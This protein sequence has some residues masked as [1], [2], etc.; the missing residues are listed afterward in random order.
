MSR[1]NLVVVESPAKAKTIGRLLG[2]GY[3]VTASMG[4]IRD[5]PERTLG[6][7]IKNGFKPVY[8]IQRKNVVKTLKDSAKGVDN[9]YLASDP[10]REGEAIA[11][12]I[13]EVL[14]S[15]TKADFKRVVF[16]EITNSAV[17][18]AFKSPSEINMNLVDAQQARRILDRIVGYQMSEFLWSRVEKGVSAG[19]VQSVALKIIC[20]RERE[21][22]NFKPQEYWNI[23]I[24]FDA[25][26]FGTGLKFK[27][28]L[29]TIG[30]EKAVVGNT[31][32]ADA[33]SSAI[34]GSKNC[35]V[36]SVETKDRKKYAPP[37]FITSTL[38]QAG[39]S[40]LRFSASHT[41]MTA[42]QLY[43]GIELGSSG[44]V[45]LITYMR[46]DSFTVSSEALAACRKYIAEKIG[47]E[48]VPNSPNHYK[49]ASRAQEAHEAIRPADVNTTPEDVKQYL[50]D[51][52]FRLYS[53]IWKRFI[54]S[55]MKPEELKVTSVESAID[56]A[57]GKDYRF[58]T[59]KTVSVFSGY[60]KMYDLDDL[61]EAGEKDDS[62]E[63][64]KTDL[65]FL[66]SLKQGHALNM[67]RSDSEQ[68]FTEPP[69]RFSEA[70]LIKEL[71]TNGIGRPSTYATFVNTILRRKY[72]LKNKGRLVPTEL[73]YKVNDCLVSAMPELF[74]VGF[75]AEMENKLDGIEEGKVNWTEMLNEFYGSFS[76]WLE[77]AR[78]ANVPEKSI[79]ANLMNAF[80]SVREWK[81]EKRNGRKFNDQSF[82]ES[83]KSHFDTTG[84]L[85]DRQWSALI[86][87]AVKY[88]NDIPELSEIG[89]KGGYSDEVQ[90]AR[91]YNVKLV[92]DMKNS[93]NPELMAEQ[94]K[95]IA[96]V[97]ELCPEP[98]VPV[99]KGRFNEP[100]FIK[101]LK[102][103]VQRGKILSEKQLNALKRIKQRHGGVPE[104][105]SVAGES[106]EQP[107]GSSLSPTEFAS[108]E[109]DLKTLEQVT[110][111]AEPVKKGRRLY[112]DKAFY[113]SINTQFNNKKSLSPKQI[114]ALAKLANKYVP[115]D[116]K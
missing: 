101:S 80:S 16:H 94:N 71:E 9:I 89:K 32:D 60:A 92:D 72:V 22:E 52:Q 95:L 97:E 50:S 70:Y 113:G 62:D 73:G 18:K 21:I 37:P 82:F 116:E 55:Q 100:Q 11:W 67:L 19:R 53:L 7:D 76:G 75:T 88:G 23:S 58:R 106:Q 12:H 38:Q 13:Q 56:G 107:G 79:V 26:P 102:R 96:D 61:K 46:T 90:K 69:P 33:V 10:D 64:E 103:Q 115:S 43:E 109:K 24:E 110:N 77:T 66:T 28:K 36:T 20:E 98:A 5:L 81:N 14:K 91:E 99:K 105:E 17:Q 45:G 8:Q 59:S 48:F 51:D 31:A 44:P 30:G 83:L 74:N 1:K 34:R 86:L 3:F 29:A 25:A 63:T 41:M 87:L 57:D 47:K 35:R 93:E 114:A 108:I 6:V 111:W 84:R 2:D 68:K 78:T 65:S 54:A 39:S 4:H 15:D 27:A 42:Q 104:G 112:D 85:T 49:S 40:S